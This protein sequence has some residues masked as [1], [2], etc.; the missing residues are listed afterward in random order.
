MSESAKHSR[1]EQCF[2]I[3]ELTMESVTPDKPDASCASNDK[4]LGSSSTADGRF[5][6]SV[7]HSYLSKR[8]IQHTLQKK[9]NMLSEKGRNTSLVLM[10]ESCI[11][12]ASSKSLHVISSDSCD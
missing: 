8:T 11:T 10:M 6:F 12:S 5:S 4:H 3:Q 9:T 2:Y 1:V 7:I